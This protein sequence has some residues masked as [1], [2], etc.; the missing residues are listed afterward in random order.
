M[1][2]MGNGYGTFAFMT[3][4]EI[5]LIKLWSLLRRT[6]K[7]KFFHDGL[8]KD[9]KRNPQFHATLKKM[10]DAMEKESRKAD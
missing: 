8:K 6:S 3:P 5:E 7:R 10:V 9:I 4:K 1:A 2:K